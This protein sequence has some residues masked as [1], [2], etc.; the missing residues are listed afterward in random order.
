MI[1]INKKFSYDINIKKKIILDSLLSENIN[2][3][4]Q[5]NKIITNSLEK[6]FL[7]K[8]EIKNIKEH[9]Y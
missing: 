7:V 9:A 5:L 6:L 2:N 1:F 8:K 3:H 4:E